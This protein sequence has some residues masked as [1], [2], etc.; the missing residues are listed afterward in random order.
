M[1]TFSPT[2]VVNKQLIAI[3]YTTNPPLEVVHPWVEEK[4]GQQVVYCMKK[5]TTLGA[6]LKRLANGE[7]GLWVRGRRISNGRT[8]S[9][10]FSK[11]ERVKMSPELSRLLSELRS[12]NKS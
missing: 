3:S 1:E 8:T 12:I 7:E 10:S 9:I 6:F 4:D 11:K 2:L 5:H